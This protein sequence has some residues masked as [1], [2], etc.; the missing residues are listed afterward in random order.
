MCVTSYQRELEW[1]HNAPHTAHRS[2]QYSYSNIDN[3][4]YDYDRGPIS[5]SE[6]VA[7]IL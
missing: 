1:A 2:K 6:W 4:D 7:L 3:Y 5:E